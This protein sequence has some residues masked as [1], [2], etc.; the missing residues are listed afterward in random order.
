MPQAVVFLLREV[1]A[2]RWFKDLG[3]TNFFLPLPTHKYWEFLR[4][5][6]E[7]KEKAA[8]ERQERLAK[9]MAETFEEAVRLFEEGKPER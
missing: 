7:E 1:K 3:F 2:D 9:E 4:L 8:K 5:E 6:E